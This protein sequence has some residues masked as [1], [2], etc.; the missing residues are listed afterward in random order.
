[1][2]TDVHRY[3]SSHMP[4]SL[5][6]FSCLSH[7]CLHMSVSLSSHVCL[8][9]HLGERLVVCLVVRV[10]VSC[11]GLCVVLCVVCWC[12]VVCWAVRVVV[13]CAFLLVLHRKTLPCVRSKR[14]RVNVQ[15][16]PVCTF[17]TLPCE[18]SERSRVYFQN[19]R[20]HMGEPKECT[21]FKTSS[22]CRCCQY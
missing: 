7:V 5:S 11:V 22:D 2:V 13:V 8:C 10:V 17:K 4:L 12:V 9:G 3:L 6:L 21:L 1:M 14:F 19:V 15:N 20:Q 18:R 16:A